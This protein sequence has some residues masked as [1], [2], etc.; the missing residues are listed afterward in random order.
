MKVLFKSCIRF[1]LFKV[2]FKNYI[3]LFLKFKVLSDKNADVRLRKK[4]RRIEK[5]KKHGIMGNL[6]IF[7]PLE[8]IVGLTL[9]F[10]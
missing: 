1:V 5:K 9:E 10:K 7:V 2:L 4:M 6:E 3:T 8:K